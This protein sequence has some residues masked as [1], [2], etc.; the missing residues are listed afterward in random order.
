[1]RLRS[2]L[3]LLTFLVAALVVG[4]GLAAASSTFWGPTGLI[5]VPTADVQPMDSLEIGLHQA[6]RRGAIT[7]SY[8]LLDV[9]EVGMGI[10]DDRWDDAEFSGFAKFNLLQETKSAPGVAI[11]VSALEDTSYFMVASKR[12]DGVGVRGHIGIG[13]GNVDGLFAGVSKV[14]NPVTVSTYQSYWQAPVTT[15]MGE[16]DGSALNLGLELAFTPNVKLRLE[17]RAMESLGFSLMFE[18]RL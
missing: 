7:I 15:I 2:R 14:L 9:L 13:K 5:N 18:T 3:V 4:N 8:G 12:L 10:F 6:N 17:A 16:W 1:M 11:G